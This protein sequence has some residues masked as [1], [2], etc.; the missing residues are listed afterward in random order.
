MTGRPPRRAIVPSLVVVR[1]AARGHW[2]HP[3]PAAAASAYD[4]PA[5]SQAPPGRACRTTMGRAER[6]VSE[7]PFRRDTASAPRLRGHGVVPHSFFHGS[8]SSSCAS[9]SVPF[10]HPATCSPLSLRSSWP[11]QL[12]RKRWDEHLQRLDDR[13]TKVNESTWEAAL[14]RITDRDQMIVDHLLK[15]DLAP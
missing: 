8:W 14:G 2:A 6:G 4:N 7:R 9:S 3:D 13:R 11:E 15:G 1:S 5:P 12:W 10:R